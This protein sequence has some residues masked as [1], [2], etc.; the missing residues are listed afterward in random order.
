MDISIVI[1]CYNSEKSLPELIERINKI[2]SIDYSFEIICV[3]DCSKDKTMETLTVLSEQYTQ[4]KV[5]DLVYN[6]GQFR[7]L[8]CGLEYASGDIVITIDDDLQ[9]RPEDILLLVNHL[10][11]NENLDVVIGA[12]KE[13]KHSFY[14]NFGTFIIRIINEKIFNKPKNL[15]TSSFRAIN[16]IV[17]KAIIAHT[18][19]FP[20][21]GPI[22]LSVTNKIENIEIEH[23]ERKY[24]RSGYRFSRLLSLTFD[25]ILN[26]SSLPL[27]Y[28]SI[29]GVFIALISLFISLFFVLK[30]LF[31]G[32]SVP[33]WTSLIIF[34]NFYSGLIL[35]SIGVIGEYLIR[36]LKESN[37]SPRYSIR[38]KI[39]IE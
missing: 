19:K 18:T 26:F 10:K 1:P 22:I 34:I 21:V 15:K 14:R 35:L 3:N 25:N 29:F 33:G 11:N 31:V 2:L 9:H 5:I 17:V 30:Y 13:K 32:I 12:Y 8:M 20:V 36:I 39:N 38:K 27:K 4:L 28:I 16:A 6:V 24:G 37:G 7:S 23:C